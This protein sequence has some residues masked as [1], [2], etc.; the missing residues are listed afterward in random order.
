M[1]QAV[2]SR[3]TLW[4][5]R[6][7]VHYLWTLGVALFADAATF[8]VETAR[9]ASLLVRYGGEGGGEPTTVPGFVV[10]ETQSKLVP[11]LLATL[12]LLAAMSA[13]SIV[14]YQILNRDRK[15][16]DSLMWRISLGWLLVLIP[17]F[18][19]PNGIYFLAPM[20]AIAVVP[21][22]LDRYPG[23]RW[24][25]AELVAFGL[26]AGLANFYSIAG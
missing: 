2:Q 17:S 9:S 18:F 10:Q 1:D 22:S 7:F 14:L 21:A 26:A 4:T 3:K 24:R 20:W 12:P 16:N 6:V 23:L 13:L 8:L 19:M 15:D 11:G 5:S 25:I